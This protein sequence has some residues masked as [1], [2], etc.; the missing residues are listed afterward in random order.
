M[1]GK[2]R[3]KSLTEEAIGRTKI[4]RKDI[5]ILDMVCTGQEG[6]DLVENKVD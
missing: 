1:R 5:A 6:K 3:R 2:Q 4:G